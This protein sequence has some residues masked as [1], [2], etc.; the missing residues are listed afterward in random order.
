MWMNKCRPVWLELGGAMGAVGSVA[1]QAV[2]I[3]VR[4]G[5]RVS[6]RLRAGACPWMG[7]GLWTWEGWEYRQGAEESSERWQWQVDG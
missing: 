6:G 3:V 1:A 5:W 4:V 7:G 2:L